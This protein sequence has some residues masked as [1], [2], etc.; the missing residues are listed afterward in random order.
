M[1]IESTYL[2]VLDGR[3]RIKVTEVKGSPAR[4]LGIESQLQ[5]IDGID[6]VS[7]NPTTGNVLVLYN[8]C[9]ITQNE[10]IDAMRALGYLREN[11]NTQAAIKGAVAFYQ[12]FS[13]ELMKALFQSTMEFALRRLV[14]ALI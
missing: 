7:A 13:G 12:T 3:L 2:H 1:N 5:R 6:R 8:S 11:G 14:S 10:V 9:Q 4:A